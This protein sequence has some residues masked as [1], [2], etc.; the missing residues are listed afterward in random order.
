MTPTVQGIDLSHWSEVTSFAAIKAANYQFVYLK[1]T[2]GEAVVDSKYQGFSQSCIQEG[3]LQGAYHFFRPELD[4]IVQ[5]KHFLAHINP[6][7]QN[8]LPYVLDWEVVDG[9]TVAADV[10]GAQKFLDYV[11]SQTGKV[12]MVYAGH[13]SLDALDLPE[14][15]QKYPLWLADYA[16]V[17]TL[18]KIWSK[19]TFWQHTSKG[20]VPG[21][22]G[23]V[24]VNYFNGT[25]QDL[26]ALIGLTVSLS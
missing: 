13:Y 18:P 17:P 11:Q 23:D 15:F 8:P 4:P 7:V 24:D 12:P 16:F 9:T 10:A 19:W 5:A 26:Y 3:L 22:S 21:V 25:L 20:T 2:E 6:K 1:C 14:S